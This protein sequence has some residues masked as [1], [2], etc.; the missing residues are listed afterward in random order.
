MGVAESVFTIKIDERLDLRFHRA[1]SR[2]CEWAEGA[3]S[4]GIE[5]DL[6]HTRK[7]NDS[8]LAMLIMLHRRAGLSGNRIRLLNCRPEIRYRVLE[9][10]LGGHLA[11]QS[12][13]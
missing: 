1:F 13:A 11:I 2:A 12:A 8:G 6:A 7:V 3:R 4:G 10:G 9:T 5:I